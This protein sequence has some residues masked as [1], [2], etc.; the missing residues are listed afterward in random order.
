MTPKGPDPSRNATKEWTAQ[1][2]L[3]ALYDSYTKKEKLFP[4]PPKSPYWVVAHVDPPKI[5]TAMK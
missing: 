4:A 2:L 3:K 5:D 1:C